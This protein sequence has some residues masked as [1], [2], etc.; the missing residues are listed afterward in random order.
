MPLQAGLS[1]QIQAFHT[2]ILDNCNRAGHPKQSDAMALR[3]R[4]NAL[5]LAKMQ[6]A[7]MALASAEPPEPVVAVELK[8]DEEPVE[9]CPA[10][11]DGTPPTW[12]GEVPD[13]NAPDDQLP[14]DQPPMIGAGRPMVDPEEDRLLF[15]DT[16]SRFVSRRLNPDESAHA[17]WQHLQEA[18]PANWRRNPASPRAAFQSPSG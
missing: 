15:G 11:C 13:N 8:R 3:L 17:I 18:N 4:A 16:L 6:L 5:A 12:P 7:M 9:E 14:D 1:R 10:G 2:A